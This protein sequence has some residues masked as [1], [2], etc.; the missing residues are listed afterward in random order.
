ME[1]SRASLHTDT[2]DSFL[3]G[4]FSFYFKNLR[5]WR[6]R[7]RGRSQGAPGTLAG[8]KGGGGFSAPEAPIPSPGPYQDHIG[9]AQPGGMVP[10][11]AQQR[12]SAGGCQPRPRGPA[13]PDAR[14]IEP[15][16][17]GHNDIWGGRSRPIILKLRLG[18][19]KGRFTGA[20]PIGS[21][22]G[23][24]GHPRAGNTHASLWRLAGESWRPS[25]PQ[26]KASS[27]KPGELATREP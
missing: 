27:R 2:K 9:R 6:L 23:R 16:T 4:A 15:P 11:T 20:K 5:T 1:K 21:K 7:I 3:F 22:T 17:K 26:A 8:P 12:W 13:Q 10:W 14:W 18:P 25:L 24:A 19:E